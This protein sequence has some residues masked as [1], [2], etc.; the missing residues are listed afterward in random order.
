MKTTSYVEPKNAQVATSVVNLMRIQI[1]VLLTLIMSCI[2][3]SSSFNQLHWKD[4]VTFRGR[5]NKRSLF[6]S[7]F[8]SCLSSSLVHSSCSISL[9][10]SSIPN[11]QMHSMSSRQK[12]SLKCS[13]KVRFKMKG[14]ELI[15]KW[16]QL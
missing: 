12:M 11:S 1:L 8:T 15:M 14:R 13:R 6:S 16:P 10:L 4:G 2:L 9:L 5:C 7:L 3:S